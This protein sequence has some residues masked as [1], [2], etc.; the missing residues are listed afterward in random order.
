DSGLLNGGVLGGGVLDDGLLNGGDVLTDFIGDVTLVD[1]SLLPSDLLGLDLLNGDILTDLIGGSIIGG[2]VIGGDLIG[3]IIGGGD[4][5]IVVDP[6]TEGGDTNTNNTTIIVQPGTTT[7]NTTINNTTVT[8]TTNITTIVNRTVTVY[9]IH[10]LTNAQR[11]VTV[12]GASR[13]QATTGSS[14]RYSTAQPMILGGVNALPSTG[15]GMTRN[16][17]PVASLLAVSGLMGLT[18]VGIRRQLIPRM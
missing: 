4:T 3:D 13:P 1:G 14:M 6:G 17:S 18:G 15:T 11:T 5:V 7:N 10:Q 2:D 12:N 8:N 16:A 9:E